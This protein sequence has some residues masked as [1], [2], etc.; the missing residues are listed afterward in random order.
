M[1]PKRQRIDDSSSQAKEVKQILYI[2]GINRLFVCWSYSFL[3]LVAKLVK[4]VLEQ[5][6]GGEKILKEYAMGGEMKD[7]TRRELVNIVVADLVE[8]YG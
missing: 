5:K 2:F 8:K 1:S 6:P 7:R 3:F 4:R